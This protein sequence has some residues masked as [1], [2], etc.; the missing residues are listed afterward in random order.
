MKTPLRALA[1]LDE[2]GLAGSAR[3]SSDPQERL[4]L[5]A[6]SPGLPPALE[7]DRF[8]FGGVS[9]YVAGKGAPLVL[10]HSVN[11]ASSAA[12][13]RPLFE[14]SLARRTVFALDLPGFGFSERSDRKYT[15]RLMT[16]ALHALAAQVRHRCG[17]EPIDAVACSLSCEFLARAAAEQPA[18]W[19]RLALISP[20]GLAGTR[21]RRGPP[22]STRGMPCLHA[23]LSARPWADALYR[24]LTRP[25][26]IRYF[27]QRTWG[28]RDIDES[29]WAYDVMT[30]RQPGARFAPLH[31]LAGSLF[32]GDIHCVY[33]S[34][35]QPVW[36]SHGVR[37]DFTDYRGKSLVRDR[38][39]WTTTIF[40]TGA[41]PYFERPS[42]F[43][44]ELEAF[45]E[46]D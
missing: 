10:V 36:M 6:Q 20:T 12:E 2:A 40:Q 16:D 29:L 25:S 42:D 4:D 41:L 39:N 45:L 8:S 15:P 44:R 18:R 34:L 21:A 33:E 35:T 26:V 30:A 5:P 37:G 13:M 31:F 3:E 22:G 43:H 38:G 14:R 32:S 46:D 19:N 28:S 9:C 23:L 11:A 17:D 24:G 1:S 27:L 7:G